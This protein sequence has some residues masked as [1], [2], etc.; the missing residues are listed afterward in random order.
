MMCRPTLPAVV[1]VTRT[2]QKEGTMLKE[3]VEQI[4]GLATPQIKFLS[5]TH[6]RNQIN[7]VEDTNP[8]DSIPVKRAFIHQVRRLRHLP[9]RLSNG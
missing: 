9:I 5:V 1:R 4:E 8:T 6:H 3:P 2:I 7:E